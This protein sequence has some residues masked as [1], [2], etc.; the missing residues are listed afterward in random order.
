MK[1]IRSYL[2]ICEEMFA[3]KQ[4]QEANMKQYVLYIVLQKIVLNNS[5]YK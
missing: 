3:V 5:P 1:A 4:G 2:E